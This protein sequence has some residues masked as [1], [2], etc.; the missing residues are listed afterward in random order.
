MDHYLKICFVTKDLLKL[1]NSINTC[2][3]ILNIILYHVF[4]N[5]YEYLKININT[6][7]IIDISI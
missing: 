7:K 5:I 3:I 6:F 2:L 1:S 4:I